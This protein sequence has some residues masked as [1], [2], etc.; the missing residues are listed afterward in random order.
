MLVVG[1]SGGLGIT[2]H[3]I[4]QYSKMKISQPSLCG[5]WHS[6]NIPE[7]SG[8]TVMIVHL[9]CLTVVPLNCGG[10]FMLAGSPNSRLGG[11]LIASNVPRH[12]LT[13]NLNG[14]PATVGAGR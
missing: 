5:N 4:V 14:T 7:P 9:W 12:P 3:A 6:H 2:L 8:R 13:R 11:A 10:C 1:S